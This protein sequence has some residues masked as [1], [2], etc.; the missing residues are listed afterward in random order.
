MKIERRDFDLLKS[1]TEDQPV[2]HGYAVRWGELSQPLPF[3]EK[4]LPGAF[5]ESIGSGSD[6]LALVDHDTGKVIGRRSNGTLSLAEDSQGLRVE[7]HPNV[8][9]TW[10]K[11]IVSLVER[12]DITGMSIGFVADVDTWENENGKQIRSVKKASLVEVSVVVNPAYAGTN[13]DK[14][15]KTNNGADVKVKPNEREIRQTITELEQRHEQ[16]LE[17]DTVEADTLKN[18]AREIR[19]AKKELEQA[20]R[21]PQE[22]RGP[23]LYA[24]PRNPEQEKL[25]HRRAFNEYLRTGRV[26]TRQQTLG[27]DTEGGFTAT[28][29]FR[30]E[31]IRALADLSCMRQIARILPPITGTQATFPRVD[32]ADA[33]AMVAEASPIGP[34]EVVFD[35]VTIT[36]SKCAALVNVSNELLKDSSVDIAGFLAQYYSESIATVIENNYWNTDGTGPL[37]VGMLQ[38]AV[39]LTRVTCAANNAVV[40]ADILDLHNGLPARY[41]NNAAWVMHPDLEAELSEMVDATGRPIIISDWSAG[42]RRTLLGKPI[43]LSDQ[44]PNTIGATED[45][46]A[47]GDFKRAFFIGDSATLDVQR[48]DSVGFASDLTAFRCVFRTDIAAALP[49]AVRILRL[50]T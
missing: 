12:R 50:D 31:I 6:V 33:A 40:L 5:R 30:A 25:E 22:T 46:M 38:A 1:G 14:R 15:N 11:D 19:D 18:L 17:D 27:T 20:T 28:E 35:Q 21:K 9:T 4:F 2:L 43:Y 29:D 8:G 39:G 13:V 10:G 36:P 47:F 44:F 42:L 16:L 24:T 49:D 34:M 32:S 41:R 37:L 7:V 3:L 48:N 23:S 26:E 45:I